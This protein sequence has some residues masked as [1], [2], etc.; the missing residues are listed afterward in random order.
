MC[1]D[2]H[3]L[4]SSSPPQN[5]LS[6]YWMNFRW[7]LDKKKKI[8][9]LKIQS[10]LEP[11]TATNGLWTGDK[12]LLCHLSACPRCKWTECNMT[13]YFRQ[14]ESSLR[15]DSWNNQN[16]GWGRGANLHSSQSYDLGSNSH[17]GLPSHYQYSKLLTLFHK[18]LDFDLSWFLH[19]KVFLLLF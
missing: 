4:E 2:V 6:Q 12:M 3:M 13:F 18:I 7:T 15:K 17:F 1:I 9:V 5:I 11:L 16:M 19:W 14:R 8:W 10:I